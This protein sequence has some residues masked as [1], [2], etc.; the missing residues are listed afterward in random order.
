MIFWVGIWGGNKK[1]FTDFVVVIHSAAILVLRLRTWKSCDP[2]CTPVKLRS[3]HAQFI[4]PCGQQE[5][6][7]LSDALFRQLISILQKKQF[8]LAFAGYEFSRCAA[9]VQG[10]NLGPQ[11]LVGKLL[12]QGTR[13]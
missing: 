10:V 4:A 6:F 8:K 9:L 11:H 2:I 7:F 1:S 13:F 12:H 3:A 5:L